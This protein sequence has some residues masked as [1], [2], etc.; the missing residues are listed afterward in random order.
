MIAYDK[1]Y[2][3]GE[4]VEGTSGKVM[5]DICPMDNSVLYTY[6]AAGK[7]DVDR[8][9]E[10]A[11]KAQPGWAATTPGEKAAMLEKLAQAIEEMSDE[12]ADLLIC[13]REVYRRYEKGTRQ[14]PVDFLIRLALYYS[15]STDYILGLT[16]DPGSCVKEN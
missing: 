2:I 5:E 6:K 13:Q 1:L 12:I 4:W 3:D 15:V 9:Y 16:D 7:E 11:R 8:A 10:A 14:I